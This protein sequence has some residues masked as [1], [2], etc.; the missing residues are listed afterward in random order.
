[1]F[2]KAITKFNSM[3]GIYTQVWKAGKI[4]HENYL[5]SFF[6]RRTNKLRYGGSKV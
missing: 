2:C 5:L 1:M 6:L 4:C 3:I